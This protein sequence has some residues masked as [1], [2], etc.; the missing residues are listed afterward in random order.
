[1]LLLSAVAVPS[2]LFNFPGINPF[3]CCCPGSRW[4]GEEGEE[5][6]RLYAYEQGCSWAMAGVIFT[7]VGRIGRIG[8]LSGSRHYSGAVAACAKILGGEKQS[9]SHAGYPLA[10]SGTPLRPVVTYR[11]N[12]WLIFARDVKRHLT[13][14]Q[15]RGERYGFLFLC[16]SSSLGEGIRPHHLCS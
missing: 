5:G 11:G 2:V 12:D 9:L 6:A 3:S 7:P 10:Q 15:Y 13:A 1:M 8:H 4:E 14:V 16:V